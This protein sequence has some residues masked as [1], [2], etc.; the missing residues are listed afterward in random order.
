MTKETIISKVKKLL[1][2]SRRTTFPKESAAFLGKAQ[3]MMLQHKID[4][5]ELDISDDESPEKDE[6]QLN[7]EDLNKKQ[8]ATWKAMLSQTLSK[9]NGCYV[10]QEGGRIVITGKKSD[11]DAVRYLYQY[12]IRQIDKLTKLDCSGTGKTYSNNFRIGCVYA[13]RNSIEREMEIKK[14]EYANNERALTVINASA[15][16]VAKAREEAEKDIELKNTK[17]RV[18]YDKVAQSR[19]REAGSNIYNGSRVKVGNQKLLT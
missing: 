9:H 19:G 2:K 6:L 15:I 11:V 16:D 5:A 18:V 8:L 1:A 17:K 7:E 12:C 3:S 4:E 13:I 10:Y 14:Q